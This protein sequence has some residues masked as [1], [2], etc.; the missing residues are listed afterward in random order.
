MKSVRAKAA[1]ACALML[2][3]VLVPV[4]LQTETTTDRFGNRG[5][6]AALQSMRRSASMLV[7]LQLSPENDGMDEG[8]GGDGGDRQARRRLRD[9]VGLLQT[10]TNSTQRLLPVPCPN[11]WDDRVPLPGD[12]ELEAGLAGAL[13]VSSRRQVLERIVHDEGCRYCEFQQLNATTM[14]LSEL[15]TLRLD[16]PVIIYDALPRQRGWN[17]SY[18]QHDTEYADVEVLVTELQMGQDAQ[19]TLREW[20]RKHDDAHEETPA[21]GGSEDGKRHDAKRDKTERNELYFLERSKVRR[22]SEHERSAQQ[23]KFNAHSRRD[24]VCVCLCLTDG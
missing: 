1:L 15:R 10:V 9:V 18:F 23:R 4:V 20:L 12:A 17:M 6:D 13:D 11:L 2:A 22:A 14:T 16:K 19:L 24:C 7:R 8:G 5:W 3:G 21:G